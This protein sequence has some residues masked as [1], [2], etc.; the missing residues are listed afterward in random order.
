MQLNE[1]FESNVKKYNMTEDQILAYQCCFHWI[2]YV[3]K[4]FPNIKKVGVSSISKEQKKDPRKTYLFKCCFKFVRETKTL[5]EIK[6]IPLYIRAQLDILRH[7]NIDNSTPEIT[8]ICLTGPKAWK[9]WKLW[10]KKYNAIIAKPKEIIQ[11]IGQGTLKALLGLET[12]KEFITK[13]LGLNPTIETYQESYLNRNLFNWI[14]FGNISPYY[15]T[16]SPFVAQIMKKEDLDRLKFDPGLYL[17][18]ITDD[19]K[20]RFK[21]MFPN[22]NLIF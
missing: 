8:P 7:I 20:K 22:E 6:E 3:E 15:V 10:Y 4:F 21:E 17:P 9:R 13:K 19:V 14:N 18:C 16:I 5:I 12:T 1:I 2:E 11:T